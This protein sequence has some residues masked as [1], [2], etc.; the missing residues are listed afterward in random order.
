[1]KG[2]RELLEKEYRRLEKIERQIKLNNGEYPDGRLKVS[3]SHNY[4]QYYHITK[5]NDVRIKRYLRKSEF[6]L[7]QKLAQKEYEI[8]VLRLVQKWIAVEYVGKSF[9]SDSA[10]IYSEKGQ[11]VRSKSEKILADYLE[12]HNIPYKYEKPLNLKGY[13]VVYP[14]FTFLS[15]KK[16][17]EVYWEH[18]GMM[19]DPIYASAAISKIKTYEENGIYI[20]DRLILTFETKKSVLSTREIEREIEQYL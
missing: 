2:L 6:D 16:G 5:E 12:R 14:D 8:K 3:N 11:R 10:V 15:S 18:E 7:V 19:D 1:M 4:M 13:G 17:K 9:A 20:G